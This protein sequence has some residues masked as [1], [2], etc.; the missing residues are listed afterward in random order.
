MRH[1]IQPKYNDDTIYTHTCGRAA[2]LEPD[3]SMNLW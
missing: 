2:A 1:F 3:E